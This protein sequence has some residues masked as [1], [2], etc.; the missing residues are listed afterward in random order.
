MGQEF[1]KATQGNKNACFY[2]GVSFIFPGFAG[3][4]TYQARQIAFKK[5][6]PKEYGFWSSGTK[7]YPFCKQIVF[8]AQRVLVHYDGV[9]NLL[10]FEIA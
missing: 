9:Q 3:V 10:L 2:K 7:M 8:C 1:G 4:Y 5:L 6:V